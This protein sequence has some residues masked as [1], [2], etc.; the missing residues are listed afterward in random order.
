MSVKAMGHIW[1]QELRTPLKFVLLA[2]GDHADHDGNNIYPSIGLIAKKTGYSERT[3]QASIRELIDIGLLEFVKTHPKLRTNVYRYTWVNL[4]HPPEIHEGVRVKS[5]TF[6][7]ESPAPEPLI[8]H[9]VKP[10]E[11]EG[12]SFPFRTAPP[13]PHTVYPADPA[14]S[15]LE[16]VLFPLTPKAVDYFATVAGASLAYGQDETATALK[17]A[18]ADWKET[19]GSNGRTYNPHNYGWI[20]WG[21]NYLAAGNKK[22][23]KD[24][25]NGHKKTTPAYTESDRELAARIRAGNVGR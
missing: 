1:D 10:S 7:G 12:D 18:L 20:E 13:V 21:I 2:M 8:N 25:N 22:T 4:L 16:G 5:T 6:M 3:V 17:I 23:W 9:Q 24:P 14:R 15:I 11:E 19:K